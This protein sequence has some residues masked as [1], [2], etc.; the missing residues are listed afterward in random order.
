MDSK[1]IIEYFNDDQY[2]HLIKSFL[3]PTIYMCKREERPIP[4]TEEGLDELFDSNDSND[5]QKFV[6]PLYEYFHSSDLGN[7]TDCIQASIH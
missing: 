1:E 7:N 2:V 6:D 5:S 4:H 3:F